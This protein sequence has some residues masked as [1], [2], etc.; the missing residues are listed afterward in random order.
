MTRSAGYSEEELAFDKPHKPLLP[1]LLLLSQ[2]LSALKESDIG[3]LV[4]DVAR[5]IKEGAGKV[6]ELLCGVEFPKLM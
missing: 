6:C 4:V 2:S 1:P 5:L 3:V